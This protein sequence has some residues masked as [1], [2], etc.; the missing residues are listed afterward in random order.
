MAQAMTWHPHTTLIYRWVQGERRFTARTLWAFG[1][2][3]SLEGCGE[4]ARQIYDP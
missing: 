4:R 1:I 3:N 2:E